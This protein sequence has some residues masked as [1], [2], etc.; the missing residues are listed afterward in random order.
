MKRVLLACICV[1]IAIST[2]A[3]LA[4]EPV[5]VAVLNFANQVQGPA[6]QEWD[7]LEKGLADLL[8]NDL[9][10]HPQL[11]LVSREQ[12]QLAILRMD[13]DRGLPP[14]WQQVIAE[15]LKAA[16]AVFGSFRI[17][18]DKATIHATV[19]NIFNDEPLGKTFVEGSSK[20]V[21]KLEKEL[22]AKVLRILTG[23]ADAGDFV[24]KLPVWTDSVPASKLLYDGV[25]HFD[26]G[27]YE[28]AWLHFR[29]ALRQDAGYADAKYWAARMYYY[30]LQYRHALAEL[31]PFI[32]E[33][34]KHPR[35]GDA[36]ME[37]VH[38]IVLTEKHI[39]TIIEYCRKLLPVI[40]NVQ[41]FYPAANLGHVRMKAR[42][43]LYLCL[44]DLYLQ[45]NDNE[46][47]AVNLYR[48]WLDN[49][50][51]KEARK[52]IRQY[53]NYISAGLAR[54]PKVCHSEKIDIATNNPQHEGIIQLRQNPDGSG[55]DFARS[56]PLWFQC[57]EKYFI[58]E[59]MLTASS[60]EKM[61]FCTLEI[62][63]EARRIDGKVS[64]D[65]KTKVWQASL[66]RPLAPMTQHIQLALII[67]WRPFID[68]EASYKLSFKLIPKDTV[69]ARVR[70][71]VIP[72][73][74]PAKL[75]F[76]GGRSLPL[77]KI[78][79]VAPKSTDLTLWPRG[80]WA[81]I[82]D[83]LKR[84]IDL[85]A[86]SL[87][88]VSFDLSHAGQASFWKSADVIGISDSETILFRG[89][90]SGHN[91]ITTMREPDRQKIVS[92]N[93]DH[94]VPNLIVGKNGKLIMYIEIFGD[95]WLAASNDDG[96]SWTSL[97]RL[98]CP[99]NTAHF[100]TSPS[101]ILDEQGRY[102]LV[103]LSDRNILRRFWPY[104][105]FSSDLIDWTRPQ[106]ISETSSYAAHLLQDNK[107]RYLLTQGTGDGV[108]VTA[109][110]NFQKWQKP[111]L[112][113][114]YERPTDGTG[115]LLGG[116]AR[117]S[118]FQW[119]DGT[120]QLF[121]IHLQPTIEY[122]SPRGSGYDM[123]TEP[124]LRT[125]RS[126]DL[127][128]WTDWFLLVNIPSLVPDCDMDSL[129]QLTHPSYTMVPGMGLVLSGSFTGYRWI[130]SENGSA[131]KICTEVESSFG[132]RG[133]CVS[134]TPK[135]AFVSINTTSAF[136]RE[137]LPRFSAFSTDDIC[138][139]LK[140]KEWKKLPRRKPAQG[141]RITHEK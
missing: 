74:V 44:G 139:K 4:A 114:G 136:W 60:K 14:E 117:A 92:Y 37:S 106:K 133:H 91:V 102:C 67:A 85:Q 78:V 105:C 115:T 103:F 86:G 120:Y 20:D 137:R 132:D 107:G 109:S 65:R 6:G 128:S 113:W 21:L 76:D 45:M 59:V 88:E 119:P 8:I 98:E 22:A 30:Q 127:T 79:E 5:A 69:T 32:Q 27:R 12:M 87:Q 80:S 82:C 111:L 104:A 41:V 53:F 43:Y 10:Q 55:A 75:Y 95:I 47:A 28:E 89:L 70:A 129:P 46:N 11:Q 99:V 1:A 96:I 34:P 29:R 62:P 61:G 58:D 112:A 101:L 7:W 24:A 97:K 110:S 77:N 116:V 31:D 81:E 26:Y 2:P 94:F 68:T 48:A 50:L 100:E 118:L 40:E 125:A 126:K 42:S 13:H 36:L 124:K 35:A 17:D 23:Q 83:V 16:R 66:I 64:Y 18:G 57:N 63:G 51:P 108:Y 73:G 122:S 54:I 3:T 138:S 39:L 38:S 131:W 33:Y 15:Q 141:S 90:I 123:Y 72:A 49:S 52:E 134:F 130:W 135:G 56:S 84:K 71:T 19:L 25:D 140:N 93:S 9:S 121:M